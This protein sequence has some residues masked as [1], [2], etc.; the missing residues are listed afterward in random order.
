MESKKFD[1]PDEPEAWSGF[2]RM[3]K[4]GAEAN[5][6]SVKWDEDLCPIMFI[7]GRLIPGMPGLDAEASGKKG[8]LVVGIGGD[9]MKN[10]ETKDALCEIMIKA[11]AVTEATGVA[12][13]NTVWMSVF[14]YTGM[15]KEDIDLDSLPR[16]SQ[17][18]N[19]I[20]KVMIMSC[21]MGGEDDGVK[22]ALADIKREEGKPPVLH[23]WKITTDMDFEGRFIEAMQF[24][25][26]LAQQVREMRAQQQNQEGE[27]WKN[28]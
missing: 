19:R 13:L 11:V 21:Q 7:H 1:M 15:E 14:D 18:P 2:M 16:P 23:N 20:E 28:Q 3:I 24:G 8:L 6:K 4:E 22:T 27:E 5:M 12:L 26:T 25:L 10:D 9:F 17:D